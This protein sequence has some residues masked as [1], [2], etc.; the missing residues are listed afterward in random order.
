MTDCAE[1]AAGGL[2]DAVNAGNS[3]DLADIIGSD[4][5][6]DGLI[7]IDMDASNL[8]DFVEDAAGGLIAAIDSGASMNCADK[9]IFR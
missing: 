5:A 6:A 4:D 8:A 3:M 2:I 9:S 7:A 1:D